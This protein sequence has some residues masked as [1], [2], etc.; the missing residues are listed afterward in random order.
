MSAAATAN[1]VAAATHGQ[2]RLDFADSVA[3]GD[4]NAHF[5]RSAV[6]LQAL[7]ICSDFR[8]ALIANLTISFQGL[9][10]NASQAPAE[11]RG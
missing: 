5:A 9:A 8:G 7:Q 1:R 4:R 3:V 10:N 2:R 11:D 6:A